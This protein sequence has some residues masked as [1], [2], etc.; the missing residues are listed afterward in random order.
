MGAFQ[1]GTACFYHSSVVRFPVRSWHRHGRCPLGFDHNDSAAV[2]DHSADCR[3]GCIGVIRVVQVVVGSIVGTSN[4]HQWSGMTQADHSDPADNH[5][6][7]RTQAD[8]SVQTGEAQ[9]SAAFNA[10][11]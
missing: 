10:D 7:R 9:Q 3:R 5:R 2:A 11:L 4:E 6:G 8:S 1:L